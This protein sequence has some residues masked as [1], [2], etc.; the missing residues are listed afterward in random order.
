MSDEELIQAALA[1]QSKA[2]AP[3]SRYRVGAAIVTP[4][5]VFTGANVEN[6]SYGLSVCAER[7]AILTAVVAGARAI[8]VVAVAT[9]TT[10]PASPCGMCR[11]TIA[12]FAPD[13]AK[14]RVIL[15][16]PRG[17]RRDYTLAELLPHGFVSADLERKG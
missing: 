11:Q 6:A 5:G 8:D 15:V 7:T 12:E 17:E 1:A 2:Y 3:Y 16:N 10:P 4:A 13:P 14:T 9:D